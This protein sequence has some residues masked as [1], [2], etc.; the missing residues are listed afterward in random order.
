MKKIAYTSIIF[1]LIF[2]SCNRTYNSSE[3]GLTVTGK[4]GEILV[5]CE[6]GIWDSEVKQHLDTQLTRFIMPYF[7]DVATFDLSHKTLKRFEDGNKRYRNLMFITIDPKVEKNSIL[8]EFHTYATDQLVIRVIAKDINSLSELIQE[9]GTIIHDAFDE[10]EWKRIMRRF[11]NKKNEILSTNFKKSFGFDIALPK[12]AQIV[13]K[14]PN[15][16]R[17]EIPTD[18]KPIEFVGNGGGEGTSFIQSGIMIY[19]YDFVDSTQF[20]MQ[21]LL[22][23]RDTMLKYNVPH[24]IEGAYMGTQYAKVVAPEGNLIKNANGNL[25]CFEMRGMF[26]F[27][28]IK[29]GTG[30]AFWSYHFLQPNRKKVICVSGYVDAP[31]MTSWI[32]PLREVQAILKSI[33]LV[34]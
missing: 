9:Q 23:A 15:F 14:R 17:I 3:F 7:P 12:G 33:E 8:K 31:S 20:E 2:L 10:I 25:Q 4:V 28:G 5:V 1:C 6:Q 18:T 22:N 13:T 19:Q 34:D 27:M 26:K 24:E 21:Q 32:L 29:H 16:Y 11:R 30:G